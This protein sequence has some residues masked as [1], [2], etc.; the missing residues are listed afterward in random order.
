MLGKLSRWLRMLGHDVEYFSSKDDLELLRKAKSENRVLL[1]RDLE[2][3]KRAMQIRVEV[4]L[5]KSESLIIRLVELAKKFD[6]ALEIEMAIS[7]C[8][9]CNDRIRSVSKENIIKEI[10]KA[11]AKYYEKFWKCIGCGQVFWQ[12]AHWKRIEKTLDD[13]RKLLKLNF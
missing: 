1:T 7:H 12:G 6:F 4:V 9:I 3:Y 5:V 2:L 11:T 13:A 10:P 8:T